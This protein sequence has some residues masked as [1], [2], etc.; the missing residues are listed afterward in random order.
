MH[1]VHRS[2]PVGPPGKDQACAV[3][4]AT[5]LYASVV[6]TTNF[7]LTSSWTLGLVKSKKTLATEISTDFGWVAVDIP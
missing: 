4:K 3:W 6:N 7:T 5:I 1:E 2:L